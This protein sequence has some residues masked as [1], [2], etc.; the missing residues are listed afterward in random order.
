MPWAV[1]SL[2][3]WSGNSGGR[4][5]A[6]SRP[7]LMPAAPA[8]PAKGPSACR[9]ADGRLSERPLKKRKVGAAGGAWGSILGGGQER[10][11]EAQ[12]ICNLQS[13]APAT[14]FGYSLQSSLVWAT[15]GWPQIP[16][17]LGYLLTQG[18]S[19]AFQTV[20]QGQ[21][22]GCEVSVVDCGRH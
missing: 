17:K 22:L 9:V 6:G 2:P 7:P 19:E 14:R 16:A 8:L 5:N 3:A 20:A 11:T 10:A 12:G 13:R 15:F 4:R 18:G 1:P 21:L